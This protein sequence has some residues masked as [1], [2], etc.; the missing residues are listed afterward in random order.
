MWCS[1]H[2]AVRELSASDTAP[3]LGAMRPCLP[4][5]PW[6][7]VDLEATGPD[8]FD[9]AI[10]EVGV[11]LLDTH[12][13]IEGEFSSLVD[14]GCA[15]EPNVHGLCDADVAN[16]PVFRSIAPRLWNLLEGRVLVGHEV[17]FEQAML[18]RHFAQADLTYDPV[19]VCTRQNL[20]LLDVKSRSLGAVCQ[21]LSIRLDN[22]H[23]ALPD[24]RAT[25][26]LL[27]H[28]LQRTRFEGQSL[29]VPF[30]GCR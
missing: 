1:F 7:V 22:P 3:S 16:A 10:V 5:G 12:G 9:A 6:A 8:P 4:D 2:R 18:R 13:Q 29:L 24:A 30:G 17:S 20:R 14:P 21:E 19:A 15:I 11:V 28:Y 23:R 26:D 27:V 25:A